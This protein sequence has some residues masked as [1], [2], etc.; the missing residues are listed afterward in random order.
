MRNGG[1]YRVIEADKKH[2]SVTLTHCEKILFRTQKEILPTI[3]KV[4]NP[5]TEGEP[6]KIDKNN[7]YYLQHCTKYLFHNK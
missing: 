1:N 4:K 7:V 5:I 2:T 3:L 6:N